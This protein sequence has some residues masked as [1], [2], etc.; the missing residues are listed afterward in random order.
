MLFYG[1]L[2]MVVSQKGYWKF[3]KLDISKWSLLVVLVEKS[4]PLESAPLANQIQ[5]FSIPYR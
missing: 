1:L 3:G 5:G 4:G 2:Y